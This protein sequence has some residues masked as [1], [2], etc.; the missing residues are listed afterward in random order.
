MRKYYLAYGSNLNLYAMAV[1]CSSARVVSAAKIRGYRLAYKGGEDG[2]AYLTLEND[3]CS[4]V[5][6]G[7]FEVTD[8][9]ISKLDLYEGYPVL[10]EKVYLPVRV[11]LLKKEALVYIMKDEFSYHLPSLDYINTCKV[12]YEHFGFDSSI[13]D[14]ALDYSISKIPKQKIYSKKEM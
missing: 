12:G 10:Y 9:D 7:I 11:H 13:L 5:P 2:C 6:V 1:R 4:K 8:S 14:E 3:P